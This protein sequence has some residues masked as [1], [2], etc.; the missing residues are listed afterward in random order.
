MDF[1]LANYEIMLNG[2]TVSEQNIDDILPDWR[3]RKHILAIQTFTDVTA[4]LVNNN[5]PFYHWSE[6]GGLAIARLVNYNYMLYKFLMPFYIRWW[7]HSERNF[8]CQFATG[9]L[10]IGQLN[11]RYYEK[12]NIPTSR[13]YELF[14]AVNPI[15]RAAKDSVVERF[16]RG[17]KCFL[18]V[19]VLSE[20]KG[21]STL[22]RA[23]KKLHTPDWCLVLC[24]LDLSN[25]H[26]DKIIKKN[27]LRDKIM[28]YGKCDYQNIGSIFATADVFV[29]PSMY[30]GWGM[31]LQEAASIGLPLIGSDMA[32]SSFEVIEEGQ[33]GY[34]FHAGN[35]KDLKNSMAN[36][37]SDP[38][39]LESH[40]RRSK[41]IFYEK[42]TVE[43]N[44]QR[45]RT[46]LI[47]VTC[48]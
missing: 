30:D 16:K 3:Q 21:I 18:F 33:N 34:I 41:E 46:A 43:R 32:A 14:Y 9:I 40:G 15:V 28:L 17:R 35:C 13:L 7:K 24:G 2:R 11:R 29:F 42:M 26:Y 47:S 31:V 8:L 36:Y 1:S 23:F 39:K 19:G 27:N 5:I 22:L 12:M 38:A 4:V 20:R 44:I 45:L 6:R 48:K 25:G 37:V 10:C